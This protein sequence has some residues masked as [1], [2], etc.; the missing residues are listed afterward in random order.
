MVDPMAILFGN[1]AKASLV[2]G[3]RFHR[4][5]SNSVYLVRVEHNVD[6]VF[7][8]VGTGIVH[9]KCLNCRARYFE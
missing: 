7:Y 1:V 6:S 5:G 9:P 3:K 2:E 4:P 8:G